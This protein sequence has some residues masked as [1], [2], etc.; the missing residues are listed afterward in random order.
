M[1][2]TGTEL[3]YLAHISED[4]TREQT[5]LQH[6]TG[7]AELASKF[8]ESFGYSD[9]GYCCGFLHDIGKYSKEFQQRIRGS[10]ERVD[11][12]TAGAQLCKKSGGPYNFISYCIAGHHA[13]LPDTGSVA[14]TSD[15]STLMGRMKKRVKDYAYYKKEIEIPPLHT[16]FL[17]IPRDQDPSF[18]VAFFIRMLFSCLVDADYLDTEDFMQDGKVVRN[19]GES[20]EILFEKLKLYISGW[21]ENSDGGTVNGRRTE[22]LTN[23]LKQ[24]RQNRGVFRL[25]VPTGGGKTVASLAFALRH[26]VEHHLNHIIYV[27]PYTSIIEQNAKVFSEILGPENVLEHH[28]NIDYDNDEELRTMQLASENWDKPVIVT[29]NVQFFESLFGNKSSK[30]RKLHSIANSV[31]IFDEAQ[32]LP[33]DY[34]QPCIAAMEELVRHYNSSIVL[35]TATQPALNEVFSGNLSGRELCP[36]MEEQFAFFR[37]TAIQNIGCLKEEELTARLN[38]EE[39]ALCILN[40]KRMVQKVYAE[41]GGEG[42]FHLSTLMYPMHRKRMLQK[43][44]ERL[45]TG[46]RCILIATS[47]VEAGVD[48]DFQ[49]VYR[50]IAGIDSVIQAAGRCNREGKRKIE[51]SPTYIF[52]L[53]DQ[54]RVT[55]QEQQIDTAKQ[56]LRKYEDISSLEAIQEY[57]VRLYRHKGEALDKKKIMD[58]FAKGNLP[59][60]K[61][62]K[63]FK[64]IQENTKIIFIP[65]ESRASEILEELKFKGATRSLMREAGQYSVSVYENLFHKLYDAGRLVSV[66]EDLKDDFFVLRDH[67]DYREDTGLQTDVELGSAV[68]F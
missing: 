26:A 42:V 24:G 65:I 7:T 43:I 56:V 14:D 61:I 18:C 15:S 59:F 1:E 12:A 31:I 49:S 46:K 62:G 28:C 8:A 27:I 44:R 30:C 5:V 16:A 38:E 41:I 50:Q 9:W 55:G 67:G 48:L 66:S 37:R 47:L 34:L 52:Q 53:E 17:N 45:R 29:T 6:L 3:K 11:H 54:E 39:Q 13:G 35:C 25:T 40:T 10:T 4:G 33:Y 2:I 20:M 19:A 57:F 36:R 58:Q 21:L 23:C 68:W 32:M 22:I 51:D 60:A 64:L 63:E